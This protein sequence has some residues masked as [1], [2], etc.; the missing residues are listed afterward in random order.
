MPELSS[1]LL[2]RA[3]TS[4]TNSVKTV[5][6]RVC[7]KSGCT[8]IHIGGPKTGSIEPIRCSV[9]SVSA[10]I[11]GRKA[12]PK[13]F[14]AASRC[15]SRLWVL[16]LTGVLGTWDLSRSLFNNS[17]FSSNADLCQVVCGCASN[18]V[19]KRQKKH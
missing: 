3:K 19:E 18:G 10:R 14:L 4:R 7:R 8:K 16:I 13:P 2:R 17:S 15:N 5:T 12:S 11:Q 6:R 9:L 1:S